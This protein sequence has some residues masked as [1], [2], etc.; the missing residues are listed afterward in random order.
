MT[1]TVE[2]P[3]A[4]TSDM[5]GL[6]RVFRNALDAAPRLLSS[7]VGDPD[8]AGV[9]GGYYA[10]VL[11]LL[12]SHHEGED[13]LL[14]PRLVERRP[15]SADVITRIAA[16]HDTVLAALRAVEAALPEWQAA[17][18]SDAT[19]AL[20]A[21]MASLNSQLSEHLDEE[22][23]QILPIAATCVNVA[24]WG[25]LPEH[26]LRTFSGDKLWLVLGLIREQM[27]PA[28]VAD[29]DAHMPPP[30]VQFWTE[31]GHTL[32]SDYMTMLNGA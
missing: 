18:T 5:I 28:Q 7:A 10:N 2:L 17:P 27:T 31:T 13:E 29:M 25:Q 23:Q 9:V 8:R 11:N 16:Q 12:H 20:S 26:G 4:D 3:L 30:V 24:E 19:E 6:H 15:E 21:R 32:F 1:D 22:E 14:T